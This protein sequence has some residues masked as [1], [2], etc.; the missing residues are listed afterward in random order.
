MT[1]LPDWFQSEIW[2]LMIGSALIC[3]SIWLGPRTDRVLRELVDADLA[4]VLAVD[5]RRDPG[6][7]VRPLR[8]TIG[9][10]SRNSASGSP[11]IRITT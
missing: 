8:G 2:A 11:G 10:S 5:A 1:S 3:A 9:W 4:V 6:D 7:H